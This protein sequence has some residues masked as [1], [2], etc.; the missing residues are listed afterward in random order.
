MYLT[1]IIFLIILMP[2]IIMP[3][4]IMTGIVS[5]HRT[6][7]QAT[8][9]TGA[10][11]LVI[12]MVASVTGDG[13]YSQM[14]DIVEAVAQ[15]ATTQPELT[16][17]LGLNKLGQEEQ[18][19]AFVNIYD[20]ALSIMPV[21]LLFM[22]AVVAYVEYIIMS[23]PLAKRIS[24]KKMPPLRELSFPHGTAMAVMLMYLIAWMISMDETSFGEMLYFNVNMLFD[25]VFALQGVTVVLMMCHFKKLPKAVGVII[26]VIMWIT[27]VGRMGLVLL[28]IAD[29]IL[30]IKGRM[31]GKA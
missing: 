10:A 17:M 1:L 16:E 19:K 6:V 20:R 3:K 5:P 23:R 30:G 26:S 11:I 14:K 21:S 4:Y 12:F 8:I 28:G 7:I 22:G 13:V 18:I 9:S 31:A 27:G 25:L 29:L 15:Q 2:L 24:V